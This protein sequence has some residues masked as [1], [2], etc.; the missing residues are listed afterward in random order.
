MLIVSL[1]FVLYLSSK[2]RSSHIQWFYFTDAKHLC[3]IAVSSVP[4]SVHYACADLSG[5]K[6]KEVKDGAHK[7]ANVK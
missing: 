2:D 6:T 5:E 7:M 4:Q 1:A 3:D